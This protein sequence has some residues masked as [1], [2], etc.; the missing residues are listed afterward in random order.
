MSL[1]IKDIG[2]IISKVQDQD[3][4]RLAFLNY[5]KKIVRV[6]LTSSKW[7]PVTRGRSYALEKVKASEDRTK[8]SGVI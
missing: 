1:L 3:K 2:Q 4:A 8:L 7:D 5:N 6:A